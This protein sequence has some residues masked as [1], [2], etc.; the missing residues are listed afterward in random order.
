MTFKSLHPIVSV[1]DVWDGLIGIYAVVD[2]TSVNIGQSAGDVAEDVVEFGAV[3]VAAS[4]CG[5]VASVKRVYLRHIFD[6]VLCDW[7]LEMVLKIVGRH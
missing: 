7:M 4:E 6:S 2:E 3:G 5:S 1:V